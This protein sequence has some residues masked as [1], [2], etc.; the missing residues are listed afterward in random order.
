MNKMYII[1]YST[2]MWDDF[3]PVNI[4]ITTDE[5]KAIEYVGKFNRI[6]NHFKAHWS[7]IVNED[8]WLDD[9]KYD[10]RRWSQIYDA[11][12]AWYNEIEIR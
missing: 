1:R 2:G 11:N 10:F 5:A 7:K 4:F 3:C 8:N 12:E 9:D 6:L